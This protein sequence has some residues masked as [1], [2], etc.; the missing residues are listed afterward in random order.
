VDE[1]RYGFSEKS[2][3]TY[4]YLRIISGSHVLAIDLG[5]VACDTLIFTGHDII[6]LLQRFSK[7]MYDFLT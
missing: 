1:R 2:D 4:N 3:H 7:S 5:Y 6:L